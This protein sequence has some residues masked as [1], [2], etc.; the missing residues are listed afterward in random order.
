M[1]VALPSLGTLPVLDAL[2]TYLLVAN[3]SALIVGLVHAWLLHG[4]RQR[5]LSLPALEVLAAIGPFGLVLPLLA[6]D[7]KLSKERS[8]LNVLLVCSLVLWS[9]VLGFVYALPL[10]MGTFL[11]KAL[12]RRRVLEI[13][14]AAASVVTLVVFGVDKRCAVRGSRRIP[15][16]VLLGMCLAGGTV[17]GLLGMLLFRHKIRSVQFAAGLP[18]ILLTQLAVFAFVVNAGWA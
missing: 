5:G 17:G 14:L 2:Q 10:D 9:V 11:G 18:L 8:W 7:R 3:V 4:S 6:W 15:E 12:I 16:A 13:Y 1:P